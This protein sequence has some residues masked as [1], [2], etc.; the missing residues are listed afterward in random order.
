MSDLETNTPSFYYAWGS[1]LCIS[2]HWTPQKN[3]LT[4]LDTCVRAWPYWLQHCQHF[5]L[6]PVE[7]CLFFSSS[8]LT[9]SSKIPKLEFIFS[10]LVLM[11]D[12]SLRIVSPCSEGR[13]ILLAFC[14]EQKK[15]SWK[16]NIIIGRGVDWKIP[17]LIKTW[18]VPWTQVQLNEIYRS[19]FKIIPHPFSYLFVFAWVDPIYLWKYYPDSFLSFHWFWCHS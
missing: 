14:F 8:L 11:P 1:L 4:A 19:I 16:D 13:N 18:K 2:G 6:W 7:N 15:G 17:H 3:C 5:E 12:S 9:S 10:A